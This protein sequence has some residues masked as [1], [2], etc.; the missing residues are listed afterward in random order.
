M[1][2]LELKAEM[3]TYVVIPEVAVAIPGETKLV[4]ITTAINRQGNVFLWPVPLPNPD[5]REMAW[6]TTARAAADRAENKWVKVV[7]NMSAGFYDIWEAEVEIA[8][9]TWT[10]HEFCELLEIAFGNG[11]L[12]DRQ[13]HPVLKQLLGRA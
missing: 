1:A 11:R 8:D 13:D 10:E 6:H 5:V 12:I 7:A 3:E 4:T 9:P 2:I